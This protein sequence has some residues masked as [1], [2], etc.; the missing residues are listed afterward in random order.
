MKTRLR[1]VTGKLLEPSGKEDICDQEYVAAEDGCR[2]ILRRRPR[3]RP[4][5]G[6][7]RGL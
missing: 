4:R 2:R 6:A 3:R 7:G 5:S 1:I